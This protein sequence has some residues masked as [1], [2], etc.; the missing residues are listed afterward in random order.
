MQT[1]TTA[2]VISLLIVAL[3]GSLFYNQTSAAPQ[4]RAIPITITQQITYETLRSDIRKQIDCLADNIYF[5]ARSEPDLGKVAVAFV[6]MNRVYSEWFPKTVC[7]VVKQR[8]RNVCQFSWWCNP[9]LKAQMLD[10]SHTIG[11]DTYRGIRQL[12]LEVYLNYENLNDITNG[13]LFF[14]A[15]YVPVSSIG[16][17]AKL[18]QTTEIGKHIFYRKEYG[19]SSSSSLEAKQVG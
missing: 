16:L 1:L 10:R 4:I 12:A 11:D 19:K 3:I 8:F 14:H 9:E 15:K 5:E 7:G 6:T 13:A 2:T 17:G 18:R